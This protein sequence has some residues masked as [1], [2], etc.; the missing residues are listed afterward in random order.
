MSEKLKAE[1]L[2]CVNTPIYQASTVTF[3]SLAELNKAKEVYAR[4]GTE[5]NFA[6]AEQVAKLENA[7]KCI[8]TPSGVASISASLLTLLQ[9]GDHLLVCDSAYGPT[10]ILCDGVLKKNGIQTNYYP[11]DIGKEIATHLKDNTKVIYLESPASLTYQIQELNE[12]IKIAKERNIITVIDN[13]WSAGTLLKPIDLGIDVSLQS[14]SK[15]LAGHADIIIGTLCFKDAELYEKIYPEYYQLG[16]HV[17]P[18]D[19]YLAARGLRTLPLRLK[20]QAEA[21][22]HIAKY[23]EKHSK[24][25]QVIYPGLSSFKQHKRFK[26]YFSGANGMLSFI[27]KDNLRKSQ[28][29]K[30][31]DALQYFKIGYSWGGF[32]NLIMY[33]EQPGKETKQLYGAPLLRLHVGLEDVK[34]LENDLAQALKIL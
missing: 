4:A 34:I 25:A 9:H 14:G 3:D 10:K 26:K 33:Y 27:C 7:A 11:S 12:I 1:Y 22:L 24:I 19:C 5:T 6:L 15:Y 21:A 20:Q 2:G 16:Y 8:I 31:V 23:L 18:Q 30:F 17:S 13:T 32:E 29:K 28:I